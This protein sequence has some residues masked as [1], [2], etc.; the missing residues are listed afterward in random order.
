MEKMACYRHKTNRRTQIKFS[1]YNRPDS[2][3]KTIW[4]Y[5]RQIPEV[6]HPYVPLSVFALHNT[7][8]TEQLKPRVSYSR[9]SE[10]IWT[11]Y[12]ICQREGKNEKTVSENVD[13]MRGR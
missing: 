12:Q 1:S 11:Q 4:P 10:Q 2:V 13:E 9:H 3:Y 7:T 5:V 6:V 8:K